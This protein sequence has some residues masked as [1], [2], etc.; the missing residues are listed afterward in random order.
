VSAEIMARS[1]LP[2]LQRELSSA[3]QR[4]AKWDVCSVLMPG[5]VVISR[6]DEDRQASYYSGLRLF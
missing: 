6:F 2:N 4:R 1:D 3:F 5:G